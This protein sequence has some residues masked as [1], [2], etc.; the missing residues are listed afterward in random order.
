MGVSGVNNL[1]G[2]KGGYEPATG[3][4][5][6]VPQ[7]QD[8]GPFTVHVVADAEDTPPQLLSFAVDHADPLSPAPTGLTM[9]FSRAISLTSQYGGLAPILSKSIEVRDEYGM[10]WPVQ[11]SA[12]DESDATIT[13]LFDEFL[14]PGHYMVQL[15]EQ[16]GL[17]DLAGLS[18]IAFGQ[19][20]HVLGQFDVPPGEGSSDPLDL[21]ALLPGPQLTESSLM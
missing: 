9:G 18:P 8:G 17:V 7:T 13:Y 4:A 19:P 5:G 10:S 20:P 3:S 15:P 6:S 14:P 11:V 2:P 12:Y 16:G 21:G 1:P